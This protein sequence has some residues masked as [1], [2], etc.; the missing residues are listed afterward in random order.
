MQRTLVVNEQTVFGLNFEA[1]EQPETLPKCPQAVNDYN[2]VR[3]NSITEC[4]KIR[5]ECRSV[6]GM[7]KSPRK[8]Y[9][10]FQ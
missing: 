7:N 3:G 1:A 5:L 8:T 6:N 4:C 10:M 2:L 9:E